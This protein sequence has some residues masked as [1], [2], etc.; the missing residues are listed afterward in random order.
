[1]SYYKI[2]KQFSILSHSIQKSRYFYNLYIIAIF[3]YKLTITKLTTKSK[4]IINIKTF[5]NLGIQ[6]IE[7]TYMYYGYICFKI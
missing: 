5:R 7:C 6:F 2:H 1:M 3:H 4:H